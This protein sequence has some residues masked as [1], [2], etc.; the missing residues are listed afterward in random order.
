MNTS[1]KSQIYL[2]KWASII[3]I[4]IH[5]YEFWFSATTF[6]ELN[7]SNR[8]WGSLIVREN[9]VDPRDLSFKTE[10]FHIFKDEKLI[11][12]APALE[13]MSCFNPLQFLSPCC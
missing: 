3:G 2:S 1:I 6:Q 11:V 13:I 7:C 12:K 4:E 8:I 10:V 9:K 5:N